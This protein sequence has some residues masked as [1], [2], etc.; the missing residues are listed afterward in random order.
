MT[1]RPPAPID[2]VP[3]S[4]LEGTSSEARPVRQVPSS[5]LPPPESL[6][7]VASALAFELA[8]PSTPPSSSLRS[9]A[10]PPASLR[11]LPPLPAIEPILDLAADARSAGDW[12]R[13]LEAYKKALFILDAS[14]LAARA[15]LYASVA[16]VKLA[17]GKTRE[18]ET[19]FEKALAANPDHLRSIEGLVTLA[20][21]AREWERVATY[22]RK[23]AFV[24]DDPDERVLELRRLADVLDGELGDRKG[25]LAALERA[26]DERPDDAA[27]LRKLHEVLVRE[28]AWAKAIE[29]LDALAKV[30]D[31]PR[32]RGG[33]RFAQAEIALGRLREEPRAIAFLELALDEDPQHD[34]ALA[35]L[36]RLRTTREEWAELAATYEKQIDRL[37][38]LGDPERAW[39][40]C[41]KL[42][43][44]RRDRLLDGPGALDAFRGAVELRADDVESRAALAELL[45]AKGDRAQAVRELEIVATHAP[46]RAQTY[47]RLFD[48]HVRAQRTDRAWLVAT[49]LEEL[50][51]GDVSHDLVVA[52]Y[53]PDGPIRPTTA[54]AE[55]WWDE[56]LR[57]PGADPLARELLRVVSRAAVELRR[58]E[59][60]G[61]KSAVVLD[62][63]QKLERTSTASIV[64]TFAWASR[65]LGIPAPDLYTSDAAEGIAAVPSAV[66][67]TVIGPD[68]R[69]GMSVQELAFYAGR[70]L[71]YYQPG[72]D[73]L[74]HYPTFADLSALVI[75]AMRVVIPGLSL[76]VPSSTGVVDLGA[77]LSADEKRALED[78]VRR[79][80][81][82]GGT[83]DLFAWMRHVELTASR[84][85][86]LLA[87]DL[88]TALRI[89]KRETSRKIADLTTDQ[90]RGDL[91]AFAASEGYATLR[92]RMGVSI[93]P[94]ISVPSSS[95][96]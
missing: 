38:G 46:T 78:V 84:V 4:S 6:R 42:A 48:F 8:S 35:A 39:E 34:R 2:D 80:D 79:I 86:L 12:E 31:R 55:A 88:R 45:A 3:L 5:L 40:H 29:V 47:R 15:S 32:D 43:M 92:E 89:V 61:N 33:F 50:S 81:E 65:V 82:R 17:Q 10:P 77:R 63:A 22:R 21:A 69:S 75:G 1:D 76:P 72:H 28:Q 53:R 60:A 30:V 23:R 54:L 27:T 49:C 91:L 24:L 7:D 94:E 57:A 96:R 36:V 71:T 44:V 18:A 13:A 83:L 95:S 85:G 87:G 59:L 25:A 74:V 68:V 16:E 51:A 19:N 90:K 64:R 70:H 14:D 62:P 73:V 56:C 41:K 26:R 9:I 66:A 37:A 52:Q 58:K 93:L 11:S 67:A 20:E